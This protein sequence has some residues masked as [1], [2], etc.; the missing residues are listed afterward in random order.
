MSLSLI[1]FLKKDLAGETYSKDCVKHGDL[2]LRGY[3]GISLCSNSWGR[4][5]AELRRVFSDGT[6]KS[7]ATQS[8][9]RSLTLFKRPHLCAPPEGQLAGHKWWKPN[10]EN[11]SGPSSALTFTIWILLTYGLTMNLNWSN[12]PPSFGN[13]VNVLLT[14]RRNYFKGNLGR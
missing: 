1:F 7:N 6:D 11:C 12:P 9:L 3:M 13:L 2:S 14:L 5:L 4:S 8:P 10:Y